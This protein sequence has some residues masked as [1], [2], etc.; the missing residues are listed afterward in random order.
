MSYYA[1]FKPTEEAMEKYKPLK[2]TCSIKRTVNEEKLA[3]IINTLISEESHDLKDVRD[4]IF[5][6]KIM[7]AG[8]ESI[9]VEEENDFAYDRWKEDNELWYCGWQ[10]SHD[11]PQNSKESVYDYVVER[12][13]ILHF[14]V[15]SGD[16]FKAESDFG[17]K[18][19]E[20]AEVLD[21]FEE[22]IRD[23]QIYRIM[24]ELKEF[25]VSD[26]DDVED[27][28]PKVDQNN[29]PEIGL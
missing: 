21:Y 24:D 28:D 22:A 1:T 8:I 9:I 14:C 19:Q 27:T 7:L 4:F 15:P 16:Y 17:E 25:R 12:L 2:F 26:D 13:A 5:K 6:T 11:E 23:V 20:I 10:Y 29:N 18:H 3:I